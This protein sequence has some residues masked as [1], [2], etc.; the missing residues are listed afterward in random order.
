MRGLKRN[1]WLFGLGVL[2]AVLVVYGGHAR[3]DVT[4]DQSGSLIFFPKVIADGT[5]DTL[6]ELTNTSNM[7]AYVHCFYVNASGHCRVSGEACKTDID[8]PTDPVVETCDRQCVPNDFDLLL[9]AQQPTM[10]RVSTGRI[11]NL[12]FPPPCRIGQRCACAGGVQCDGNGLSGSQCCPGDEP[13]LAG[14]NSFAV[15][16]TGTDFE[17]LLK[18][19]QVDE[20]FEMPV[21][22]NSLKGEAVLET[23]ES[24]QVSEYNALSITASTGLDSNLDLHLLSPVPSGVVN[25]VNEY[26]GCPTSLVLNHYA[27]G[28]VDAFS[29]A[30][31]TTELTLV[32]CTDLLEAARPTHTVVSFNLIDE[33]EDLIGS[34]DA[35]GFDCFFNSRLG[36]IRNFFKSKLVGGAVPVTSPFA[37]TR[38]KVSSGSVCYSGD[39]IGKGC[40]PANG[41]DDC[42]GFETTDTGTSLG[43]R[44]SSAV[45]G[46]AEEFHSII[47][48]PD[49]TAA[50]NLIQEGSRTGND[51]RMGDLIVA[52]RL[53]HD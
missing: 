11:T 4:T 38:I 12:F 41:D 9:T 44:A 46:V 27:D 14:Q 8:C 2:L 22:Q 52:P 23:L 48:R 17:G 31:V 50:V 36:D 47:G 25:G 53:K 42:T 34:A 13:G 6:I 29:G 28:A 33:F 35:V 39:N 15:P 37:K 30:S 45:L 5:R 43:C 26:N 1:P 7:A 16:K 40:N 3:A 20:N 21:M 24:G 19:V 32:P 18:C 49:G 51:G 10:W